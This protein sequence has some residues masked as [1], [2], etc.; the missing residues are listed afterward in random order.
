MFWC[1]V[2]V[3]AEPH[4]VFLLS[5]GRTHGQREHLVGMWKVQWFPENF[6]SL[7][8]PNFTLC[9][10]LAAGLVRW[11]SILS[12]LVFSRV[13]REEATSSNCSGRM[14]PAVVLPGDSHSC[15]QNMWGTWG[16][17]KRWWPHVVW[18]A[19]E[20]G[21]VNLACVCPQQPWWTRCNWADQLLCV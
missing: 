11:A 6:D 10:R 15:N 2:N 13:C 19:A 3:W 20:A 16:A 4:V 17:Q 18:V 8:F 5:H 12:A 14:L 7:S 21:N 9:S 1:F